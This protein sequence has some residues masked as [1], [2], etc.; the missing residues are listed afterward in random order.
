MLV[1]AAVIALPVTHASSYGVTRGGLY[2]RA[3]QDGLARD[4]TW[5]AAGYPARC[6]LSFLPLPAGYELAPATAD[7]LDNV[8]EAY[9]WSTARLCLA[10]RDPG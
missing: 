8:V 6:Q 5:S 10:N 9:H 3:L 4:K 2:Y 1:M 7:V